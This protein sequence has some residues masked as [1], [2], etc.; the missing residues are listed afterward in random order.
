MIDAIEFSQRLIRCPSITPA[1]G[2]ALDLLQETLEEIGFCCYRLVFSEEGTA[3]VD[4]LYARFGNSAPNFCFAGHTDVVPPGDLNAWTFDPFAAEIRDGIL[5]GRGA[6][7]MKTAIASFASAAEA[8]ISNSSFTGSISFLITGDEEGP[9]INGTRKVL[10]WLEQ[11][12]ETI[13]VCVVGEPTNP[14][15]LGE[16]MKIGR[17]GSM[18]SIVKVLGQQG[19][20]AYPHLADSASHRLVRMMDSLLAEPLDDGNDHFQASS[21][22]ITS[23]DIANPTENVIPGT[24]EARFNIRFN[25]MHSSESL[26]K[27]IKMKLDASAGGTENYEITV[28]VSG[29]SFVFPPG[30]LSNLVADCVERVTGERPEMSTTGGTSDARFIKDHCHVCEFGLVGQTMHKVDERCRLEDIKALVGIYQAI[31]QDYF[32]KSK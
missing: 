20:V 25:D 13:D 9:A 26:K 27:W 19:H 2:G 32:R 10:S 24:A 8:L 18:N 30:P 29:E 31:L 16:M 23:I 6:V 4:N 11:E 21:L 14:T 28:R 22:Q 17:R 1:E 3:D 15:R 7:D 12:N 5:Y